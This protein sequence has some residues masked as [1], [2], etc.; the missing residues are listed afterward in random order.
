MVLMVAP[1]VLVGC[2][3][4]DGMEYAFD[5]YVHRVKNLVY[6]NY[7]I[8]LVD[9]SSSDGYKRKLESAGFI[10][11]K[12]PLLSNVQERVVASR[13]ILRQYAV[14]K[15]YD[16][17]LMLEQ[18]VIPPRPIIQ[19]LLRHKKPVVTGV[20]FKPFTLNVKFANRVVKKKS[21]RPVLYKFI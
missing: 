7:D 5:D 13:N 12:G 21:I 19:A 2:P 9:N 4:F 10:V 20:Y 1:K 17:M 8:V 3:T 18:D 15:N 14:D 16:Y 11:L 6:E